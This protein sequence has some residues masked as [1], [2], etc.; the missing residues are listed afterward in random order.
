S[1]ISRLSA[2]NFF[3]ALKELGYRATPVDVGRDFGVIL[4]QLGADIVLNATHGEYG[5]DGCLP[6]ILE[7][8]RVP[9]THSGVFAS[10]VAM[11]KIFSRA[12]FAQ[13]GVNIPDGVIIK[14]TDDLTAEPMQRPFVIKPPNLGSSIG[15]QVIFPE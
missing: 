9:Y 5:E 7:L 14:R 10:A 1:D 4:P 12:F 2:Q 11:N 3:L 8:A 15:V 6:G 13:H